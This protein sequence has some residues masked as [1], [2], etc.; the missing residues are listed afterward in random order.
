MYARM[1]KKYMSPL[2][3]VLSI[4]TAS[5]LALSGNFKEDETKG[6]GLYDDPIDG[7]DAW[8]KGSNWNDIWDE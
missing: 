1:K 7:G 8:T 3:T 4:S 6:E 5:M 2:M